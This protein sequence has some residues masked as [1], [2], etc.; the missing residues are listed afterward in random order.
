MPNKR[1]M[2]LRNLFAILLVLL[3]LFAPLRAYAD[4]SEE[5]LVSEPTRQTVTLETTDEVSNDELLDGYVMQVLQEALPEGSQDAPPLV[6]QSAVEML[7]GKD[8]LVY[9][10]LAP[11]IAVAASCQNTSTS[12]TIPAG[13]VL[14]KTTWTSADLGGIPIIVNG[15]YNQDALDLVFAEFNIGWQKVLGALVAD[16]PYEM[17]WFDKTTGLGITDPGLGAVMQ[18]GQ[19]VLKANS[20]FQVDFAVASDYAA[21]TYE[22]NRGISNR[23]GTAVQKAQSIVSESA[24]LS[25]YDRLAHFRD[26][27]CG[28]VSYDSASASSTTRPFGDPWQLIAVFDGDNSTNVV[29]EGYAKAFKYL[30]DMADMNNIECLTVTGRM[31]GGTGAGLHMWNVVHMDDGKTY[32]VDVTNCDAGTIGAPDLLFLRGYDG[33]SSTGTYTI[34]IGLWDRMRYTYDEDTHETYGED[35]L[36][37]ASTGYEPPV[38]DE[39]KECGSCLWRI[40][41]DGTLVVKPATGDEGTL[42]N[43]AVPGQWRAPWATRIG[44]IQAVRFEGTIHAQTCSRMFEGCTNASSIDLTGLDTS[45]VTDMGSMFMG[46]SALEELDLSGLDTSHVSNWTYTFTD[47]SS[48]TSLDLSTLD[49]SSSIDMGYMMQGCDGLEEWKVGTG[50]VLGGPREIGSDDHSDA[51]YEALPTNPDGKWWSAAEH[52]WFTNDEICDNRLGIADTYTR[53]MADTDLED[54]EIGLEYSEVTY[55]GSAYVPDVTV[56]LYGTQLVAGTDY[57]LSIAGNVNAGT[58]TVTATGKGAYS[59]TVTATFAILPVDLSSATIDIDQD[60]A[61]YDGQQVT[62]DIAVTLDGA[63]LTAGVDYDV[64]TAVDSQSGLYQVSVG[65]KGNYSGTAEATFTLDIF[66]LDNAEATLEYESTTYTGS[67]I[68]PDV[69]IV[70]GGRELAE[71]TDYT[72]S[73]DNNT[74]CTR[75]SNQP[76]EAFISARGVYEGEITLTFTIE[77][78]D[79]ANATVLLIEAQPYNGGLEVTPAPTVI[80]KGNELESG[81]DWQ[82]TYENNLQPGTASLTLAGMNNFAGSKK[83]TFTILPVEQASSFIDVDASNPVESNRTPHYEDI[84]WLASAGISTGWVEADGTR[85][86]RG[87]AKVVRQDMAAFLYRLAGSPAYV[88]TPKDIQTF[89]DVDSTNIDVNRRTPHYIEI[90]WLANAGIS[91]GWKEANGTSTFRGGDTVKRQDMAAFLRRLYNYVW[92]VKNTDMPAGAVNTFDDVNTST[93]HYANIVWMAYNGVS[94]GWVVGGRTEYRGMNDVLRQDMAAFLH[95]LNGVIENGEK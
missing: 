50:F 89:A 54:A 70:L 23:V 10:A 40:E 26:A 94:T 45:Q 39:W 58:A 92:N 74:E 62:A 27:I 18:Q 95:R 64:T 49:T 76:A 46:C 79:I 24:S 48:L 19:W 32:L 36:R 73:Y 28:L 5:M 38:E 84:E 63:I 57:E 44:E 9:E 20:D 82:L 31:S 78:A 1:M 14:G 22:I 13:A 60:S 34:N 75:L 53:E 25:A 68:E 3:V 41:R 7:S 83:V 21:G 59:G 16:F 61:S 11:K 69:T 15:E 56:T 52:K 42:S 51:L 65:G 85:T 2:P 67:E 72:V 17:Y 4:E 12:F 87:E 30:C 33:G 6:T 80:Y 35:Q 8:L 86:F 93:P 29:C 43:W 47:C 91:T 37:L 71:G 81:I 88:P 55:S 90:L 66:D 77:P